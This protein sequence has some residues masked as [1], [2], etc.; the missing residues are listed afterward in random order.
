MTSPISETRSPRP[1]EISQG[2]DLDTLA[3]VHGAIRNKEELW[4]YMEGRG[5]RLCPHAVGQRGDEIYV[6]GLV[7]RERE[8][9]V[10]EGAGW[11]WLTEWRWIRLAELQIPVAHRGEWIT[12]PQDRRPPRDF[13]TRIYVEAE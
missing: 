13:L 5:I 2:V 8:G 12:C 9:V 10:V 7:I 3:L 11:E 1:G 4:G 6:L